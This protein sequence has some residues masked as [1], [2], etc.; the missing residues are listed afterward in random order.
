MSSILIPAFYSVYYETKRNVF[1]AIII[2][3]FSF[4]IDNAER[5]CLEKFIVFYD[6]CLSS[7]PDKYVV[8]NI[9]Q[10]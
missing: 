2:T 6:R 1:M 4:D 9:Y 5:I 10:L 3:L 8:C 7:E